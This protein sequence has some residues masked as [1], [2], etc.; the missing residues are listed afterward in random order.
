MLVSYKYKFIFFK[1]IKTA[2][3]SLFSFFTPYCIPDATNFDYNELDNKYIGFYKTGIVGDPEC[4][5][6]TQ[7]RHVTCSR[8][9]KIVNKIDEKIWKK[10]YKFCVVRNPW[11][12][13]V[14]KYY[15]KVR[16]EE[17]KNVTFE[18][19]V[20]IL[21]DGINKMRT[22]QD[23]Y[24]MHGK[25][26]NYVCD[27]HIKYEK[28][29]NGIKKV[30]KNCNIKDYDLKNLGQL[31][32]DIRDKSIHYSH[33]YNN[34]TKDIVAKLYSDDIKRFGYEFEKE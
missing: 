2:S 21:D 15:W 6:S 23:L 9:K 28:L 17:R 10:Y 33:H 34:K 4:K 31:K 12:L 7:L 27:F 8:A 26:N 18:Y 19:F 32:S 22:R 11:D 16:K 20:G 29:N 3:S 30:C 25:K 24:K 14:S 5:N 13:V 1:T